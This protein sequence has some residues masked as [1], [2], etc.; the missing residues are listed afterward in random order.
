MACDS[1]TCDTKIHHV[2]LWKN[3]GEFFY[4]SNNDLGHPLWT[5]ILD[6]PRLW[7]MAHN[8]NILC[9]I[10]IIVWKKFQTNIYLSK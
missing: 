6:G 7:H 5:F 9:G 4:Y 3:L 2:E 10:L 1:A 8:Q